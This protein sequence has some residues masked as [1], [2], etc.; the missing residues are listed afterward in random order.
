MLERK[1]TVHF[2]SHRADDIMTAVRLAEEFGFEIVLQHCTEGY[3]I[4]EELAK[5]GIWVSLTLVDSPGGKPEAMGLLEENAAILNKAGVKVA[6][7]TD[8]FITESRFF[9]R[10]GAI[11]VRG[12]MSEDVALKAPDP[13]RG[14][15]AAPGAPLRL[16]RKGQ[17]RRFRRAVWRAV[18]RLHAGAGDLHRRRKGVR[19]RTCTRTGPTRPAAL[20]CRRGKS[21]LPKPAVAIKSQPAAHVPP[22]P[23]GGIALKG[24]P[25]RYAVYAGRLHT[26]AN[27]TI[28][29]GV[30]LVEDGKI[31]LRRAAPGL[32]PAARD[33]RA[34]G[35]SRDAGADR[36]S[37]G[38]GPVRGAELRRPTRTRTKRA[39]PTRPIC[40]CST[41]SIRSEPLLEFIREQGVTVIHAMP[42]RANVIA[43]QTGIF[44]T[45]GTT[46]EK[47]AVRFPAGML[48][49]LGEV[50][51]STYPGKLP[52]RAWARPTSSAQR[53]AQA[54][55]YSKR[56]AGGK[57]TP[58]NLKLDA[59]ESGAH[60]EGTGHLQRPPRRRP[61]DRPAPG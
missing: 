55:A 15:D 44:R 12:G 4:A 53:C 59:L 23:D 54:Q 13:P 60:A 52:T 28:A 58:P 29:D 20:P 41:A 39:I 40:A 46:A 1:R 6:I 61:D 9:L 56:K 21:R 5:R 42:G 51:K 11:A 27:G 3:R 47:M 48:V 30:V 22:M 50:P 8:D 45:H 19:S 2:H 38:G 7:N 49:N 33:G 24:T 16:A 43:G 36:R 26:V 34:Y 25:K 37:Y 57:E 35:G 32:Q 10:T 18:Q 17:G 14:P 31:A